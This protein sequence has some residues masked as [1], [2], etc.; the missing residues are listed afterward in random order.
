MAKQPSEW[1]RFLSVFREKAAGKTFPK[2]T[3]LIT[4]LMTEEVRPHL[5]GLIA[6]YDFDEHRSPTFGYSGDE[7]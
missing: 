1:D 3:D 2:D 6:A 7:E 4:F 5:K